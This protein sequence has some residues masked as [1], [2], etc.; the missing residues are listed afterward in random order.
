MAPKTKIYWLV[1]YL[2]TLVVTV[3]QR[4]GGREPL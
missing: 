3:A 2:S 1:G 4:A